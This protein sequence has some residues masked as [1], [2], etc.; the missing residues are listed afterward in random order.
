[1]L[2]RFWDSLKRG[3][4]LQHFVNRSSCAWLN[5]ARFLDKHRSRRYVLVW[6]FCYFCNTNV[7]S[8]KFENKIHYPCA[9]YQTF[10]LYFFVKP[11]FYDPKREN[12][13]NF[14]EVGKELKESI[15]VNGICELMYLSQIKSKQIP[16]N[17]IVCFGYQVTALLMLIMLI[18]SAYTGVTQKVRYTRSVVQWWIIR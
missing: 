8:T 3:R 18:P 1:M 14:I 5:T 15:C 4:D 6:N 16:V 11:F 2:L 17:A 12:R 10:K 9:F 7:R 13:A